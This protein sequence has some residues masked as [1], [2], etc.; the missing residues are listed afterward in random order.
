M[1]AKTRKF[2]INKL[3]E[4]RF[5]DEKLLELEDLI[6]ETNNITD[7]T[8]IKAKNK[9]SRNVENMA[10]RLADNQE[11]QYLKKWKQCIDN[12][13]IKYMQKT[14]QEKRRGRP[15]FSNKNEMK[16]KIL[17][18]RF[19]EYPLNR[20]IN[21]MYVYTQLQLQGIDFTERFFRKCFS[22]ILDD[23]YKEAK[24]MNLLD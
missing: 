3:T 5:I 1:E 24:E 11:Y 2:I 15:N 21:N 9:I 16:L 4:Y 22:I 23:V 8:G 10:I 18:L 19:I 12:V 7:V 6:L 14:I 13:Q 20:R 17:R